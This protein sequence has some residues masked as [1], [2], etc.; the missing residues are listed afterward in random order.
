MSTLA[1]RA[2]ADRKEA[3][4]QASQGPGMLRFLLMGILFGIVLTKS[5]VISWYRIQEMFRFQAFHM[6]GVLGSAV[7]VGIVGMFLL[8]VTG[9]RTT[10]GATISIPGRE[11]TR[12]GTRYWLGGTFFGVGWAFTGACPGP[13]Y[14]LIGSGATAY[15]A[16]VVSALLG[17]VAY[18]K[19]RR[20]L[21]H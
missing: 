21:P 2:E 3:G 18:G 4:E 14:A 20:L 6:Y 12:T 1:E 17:V 8:R 13:V 9:A 5:E 10:Y 15:L 11:M 7:A 16:V 19:L